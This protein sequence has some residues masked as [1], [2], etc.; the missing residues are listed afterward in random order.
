M[1]HYAWCPT[2]YTSTLNNS[3]TVMI[4]KLEVE[5]PCDPVIPLSVCPKSRAWGTQNL[6]LEYSQLHS[7]EK[8]KQSDIYHLVNR[9]NKYN[10]L[11]QGMPLSFTEE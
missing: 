11:I 10:T 4:K 7:P 5:L 8:W 2:W 3:L 6:V 9:Q 1:Y